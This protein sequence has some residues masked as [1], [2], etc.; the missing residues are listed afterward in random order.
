MYLNMTA[1]NHAVSFLQIK[2]TVSQTTNSDI[3]LQNLFV[4]NQQLEQDKAE[5][6]T[7]ILELKQEKKIYMKIITDLAYS[8]CHLPSIV[9]QHRSIYSQSE[10]YLI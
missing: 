9:R 8:A 7:V 10:C 3:L 6:S 2:E 1:I 5:M 4:E